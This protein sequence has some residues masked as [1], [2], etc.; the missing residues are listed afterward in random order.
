MTPGDSC[1]GKSGA[2]DHGPGGGALSELPLHHTKMPFM[3]LISPTLKRWSSLLLFCAMLALFASGAQVRAL[4]GHDC[5]AGLGLE[6]AAAG[7]ALAG[8]LDILSWNIQKASNAGWADDLAE[9]AGDVNLAFIQEASLQAG[10]S[11]AFATPLVQAFAAGYTTSSLDTGVM[12]LSTS[13]PLVQCNFTAWEPWLG[14]PKATSITEYPLQGRDE[15]LLTINLHAV[16]FA[17]GIEDFQAQFGALSDLLSQHQGPVILAGD[18]NTWS[19][20]R[21]TLVD[22]F[23]LKHG[24]GPV[25]FEPDLRTTTF[26]YALDHIYIRGMQATFAQVIPV[27]S[28]DHNPLRVRL[29]LP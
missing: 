20:R 29:A 11:G 16:N 18:L 22:E 1:G 19:G 15:R 23:M 12:T 3:S 14:T 13:T 4:Q 24:L 17:F 9:I 7:Q 25:S 26:G 10:I 8:E 21:Q 6:T 28:S 5:A 2:M 27:S